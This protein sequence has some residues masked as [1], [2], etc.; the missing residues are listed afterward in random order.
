[1]PAALDF[2]QAVRPLDEALPPPTAEPARR[3]PSSLPCPEG[4]VTRDLAPGLLPSACWDAHGTMVRVP[5][6]TGAA[7]FLVDW[8]EVTAADYAGCVTDGACTLPSEGRGCHGREADAGSLP[9]NCVDRSQAT[10][11]CAWAHRRLCTAE[12]HRRAATGPDG[13]L[14]PWGDAPADCL[15][16]VRDGRGTPGASDAPGCGRGGPWPVGS[17]PAGVGPVGALDLCGN[18][19]EWVAAGG[20][21]GGGYLDKAPEELQATGLRPIPPDW[22]LPDVGFRC[23]REV[24]P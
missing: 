1:M 23:C 22:A 13:A 16:A 10:T 11:W 19:A 5:A 4:M 20:A 24:S 9:V 2:E 17:R 18:V 7:A 3:E 14:Y 12:E 6:E 15:R 21:A 8:T